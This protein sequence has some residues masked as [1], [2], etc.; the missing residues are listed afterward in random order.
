MFSYTIHAQTDDNRA[1]LLLFPSFSPLT[2][3]FPKLSAILRPVYVTASW[4]S[5]VCLKTLLVR[6]PSSV[7]K[8]IDEMYR[9]IRI[10]I[11]RRI[12]SKSTLLLRLVNMWTD[13]FHDRIEQ[14][15]SKCGA[16]SPR[17]GRS[18]S[19][20]GGR[21]VSIRH[22]YFERNTGGRQNTYLADTFLG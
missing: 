3:T 1:P 15:F 9:I 21:V 2:V 7:E 12:K 8:T 14:R 16:P 18:W 22:I 19:S 5:V 10:V 13:Y 6:V 17:G 11:L 20:W 4:R